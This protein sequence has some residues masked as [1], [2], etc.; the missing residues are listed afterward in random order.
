LAYTGEFE[1]RAGHQIRTRYRAVCTLEI[2]RAE[3]IFVDGAHAPVRTA[4]A[5]AAASAADASHTA[6]QLWVPMSPHAWM[7]NITCAHS[8]ASAAQRSTG[9]RANRCDR[10]AR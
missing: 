2:G 4:S 8:D 5:P 9:V 6:D 3:K 1:D 7:T 10:A